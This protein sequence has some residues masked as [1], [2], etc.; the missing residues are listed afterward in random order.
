MIAQADRAIRAGCRSTLANLPEA[1]DQM[2]A[3]A[4]TQGNIIPTSMD[5]AQ[6]LLL[7]EHLPM[8]RET[9]DPAQLISRLYDLEP[10]AGFVW[11]DVSL[12][13]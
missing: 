4:E 7:K 10:F 1:R 2:A 6:C 13:A 12:R 3:R 9:N 5:L 8:M 11:H